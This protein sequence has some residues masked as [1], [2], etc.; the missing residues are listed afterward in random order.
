MT[1]TTATTAT[2]PVPDT[3]TDEQHEVRVVRREYFALAD[4]V[5][6]LDAA[7]FAQRV[8]SSSASARAM[9]NDVLVSLFEM[10]ERLAIH[11]IAADTP[12]ES[13]GLL[14]CVDVALRHLSVAPAEIPQ[15]CHQP[16][17]LV[18]ALELTHVA[19]CVEARPLWGVVYDRLL[20]H[21]RPTDV[22]ARDKLD[23]ITREQRW[24]AQT[25]PWDLLTA[26][27]WDDEAANGLLASMRHPEA[28]PA[29]FWSLPRCCSVPTAYAKLVRY[30]VPLNSEQANDMLRR[31]LSVT[32]CVLHPYADAFLWRTA[33]S[34]EGSTRPQTR[35]HHQEGCLSLIRFALV[36]LGG[37]PTMR[38]AVSRPEETSLFVSQISVPGE[39]E[40]RVGSLSE[41][42]ARVISLHARPYHIPRPVDVRRTPVGA[43]LHEGDLES[44]AR[45][46]ALLMA[47]HPRLGERSLLAQL[48]P[49]LFRAQ[50]A[51][52]ARRLVCLP[53][54][55]RAAAIESAFRVIGTELS[56]PPDAP[57]VN[58][59]VPRAG[60]RRHGLHA[61]FAACVRGRWPLTPAL[62]EEFAKRAWCSRQLVLMMRLTRLWIRRGRKLTGASGN[63]RLRRAAIRN[64]AWTHHLQ[65]TAHCRARNAVPARVD[66]D[67]SDAEEG[68]GEDFFLDYLTGSE[69]DDGV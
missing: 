65:V 30:R 4:A 12:P 42:F 36:G 10:Y 47:T 22:A 49:C 41:Y 58:L 57:H 37:D 2:V 7:H 40:R 48:E 35:W 67:A 20:Q 21:A 14:A 59:F 61:L 24:L 28:L 29:V 3:N 19:H 23:R 52:A 16:T 46:L 11:H 31:A 5:R 44:R 8:L 66:D 43:L 34:D 50:L 62:R 39:R 51:P 54:D 68:E 63:R 60:G 69:A 13:Q 53:A 56:L 55:G 33:S 26:S 9:G 17:L 25:S 32:A 38:V 45:V 18:R 27:P 1:T 64:M 15:W 6:T